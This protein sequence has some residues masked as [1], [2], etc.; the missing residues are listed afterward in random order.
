[1]PRRA[2]PISGP[3][4]ATFLPVVFPPANVLELPRHCRGGSGEIVNKPS[5]CANDDQRLH[6]GGKFSARVKQDFCAIAKRRL[7][8]LRDVLL[9]VRSIA[10]TGGEAYF[11]LAMDG[12]DSALPEAT[13]LGALSTRPY[14]SSS[15]G[16][17]DCPAPS[18][19]EGCGLG[20]GWQAGR[21][22]L[23]GSRHLRLVGAGVAAQAAWSVVSVA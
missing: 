12:A 22:S 23:R 13:P 15:H 5:S 7:S 9:A 20:V 4:P 16:S 18:F 2:G 11:A 17:R 21:T 3:A 14:T 6:S 10:A 1:M 19:R 8:A